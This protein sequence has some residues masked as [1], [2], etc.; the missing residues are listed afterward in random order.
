MSCGRLHEAALE[1]HEHMIIPTAKNWSICSC[2]SR[3]L[4][5]CKKKKKD[6]WQM[7]GQRCQKL[8]NPSLSNTP[9]RRSQPSS[10]QCAKSGPICT[11]YKRGEREMANFEKGTQHSLVEGFAK[12]S[13]PGNQNNGVVVEQFFDLEFD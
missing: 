10:R 8:A 9:R 7:R 2:V 6:K 3:F 12:T 4:S 5:N 1:R 11:Q 13:W